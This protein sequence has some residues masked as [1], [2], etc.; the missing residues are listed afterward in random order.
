MIDIPISLGDVIN[1]V[2]AGTFGGTCVAL[3]RLFWKKYKEVRFESKYKISG[4][5]ISFFDDIE[6]GRKLVSQSLSNIKQK[7]HKV[8]IITTLPSGRSWTLRG[9]ML[10]GGHV[11]GV[12]SA[13]APYDEGIGSF[14]LRINGTDLDGM[15][16]GYDHVNKIITSGR[17]WFRKMLD[18][19]IS[20][21]EQKDVNEIVS[22]AANSFGYGYINRNNI[23]IGHDNH[24][25]F[26]ARNGGAFCGFCTSYI[27]DANK[28]REMLGEYNSILPDDVRIADERGRLGVI[29]T[30]SVRKKYQCRGIGFNLITHAEKNLRRNG[31]DC[32]VVP[33]WRHSD[34]TRLESILKIKDYRFW[35]RD[36]SY[37]RDSCEKRQ[38]QCVNFDGRCRCAVDFYR[39][40]FL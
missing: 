25:S 29:K 14:Y 23:V 33:A 18:V 12:Y 17:Y 30:I 13:D 2:L 16:N 35:F 8:N 4:S 26:I 6:H 27:L 19:S 11:S 9:S 15:W 37:W 21:A 22:S 1:E 36:N 31:A 24:F 3:F 38:F 34:T 32:I 40:G 28:I 20:D 39:H 5:Y 7:G 10:Y